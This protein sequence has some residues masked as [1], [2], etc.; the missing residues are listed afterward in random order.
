MK[1][2]LATFEHLPIRIGGL[3]EAATS[4]GE[5]LAKLGED[6]MVLMPSHG[7]QHDSKEFKLTQIAEFSIQVGYEYFPTVV[8]EAKRKGV[9]VYL[10]SNDILDRKE[11]YGEFHQL[12]EKI[13][14]FAKAV[15][16]FLNLYIG[17]TGEK[18]HVF[19][20][21]DWHAILAAE[22]AKKYFRIPYVYTIHRICNPQIPYDLLKEKGFEDI[23]DPSFVK[24][25]L[26]PLEPFGARGC[27]VLNTVSLTYLEEEW[28]RFF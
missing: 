6:V 19:H 22:Y 25:G 7:L 28:E 14:H 18:P 24:D 11:V 27:K 13:F 21:N 10:L 9:S 12:F 8:Y 20:S 1:I 16:A 23:L 26:Y 15:P 3:S 4:L 2:A 5:A 17:E